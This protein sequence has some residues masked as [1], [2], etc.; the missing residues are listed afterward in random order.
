VL[1]LIGEKLIN[2]AIERSL[3]KKLS[4]M[5]D[6]QDKKFSSIYDIQDMMLKSI[7][8]IDDYDISTLL[9]PCNIFFLTPH[10]CK[11]AVTNI[12][13]FIDANGQN[14]SPVYAWETDIAYEDYNKIVKVAD[15]IEEWLFKTNLPLQLELQTKKAQQ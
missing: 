1:I 4:P 12:A 9:N 14:D 2:T 6:I 3:Y 7:K 8:C 5:Y 11:D 13:Y 10:S 15:G